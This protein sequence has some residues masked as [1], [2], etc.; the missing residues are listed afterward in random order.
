[1]S[2]GDNS[3]AAREILDKAVCPDTGQNR[4]GTTTGA[5]NI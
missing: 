3:K 4:G 5:P 1:M 2:C